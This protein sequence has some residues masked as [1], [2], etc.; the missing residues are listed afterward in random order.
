MPL[1]LGELSV[2]PP[3]LSPSPPVYMHCGFNLLFVAVCSVGA[4]GQMASFF[5]S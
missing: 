1:D 4:I 5:V 3:F 2:S